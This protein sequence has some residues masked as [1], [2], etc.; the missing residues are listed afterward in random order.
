MEGRLENDDRLIFLMSRAQHCLR[1]HLKLAFERE[2]LGMTPVQ[3]GI[4]FLLQQKARTM[5]SISRELTIDNSATTGLV[6]RL[7]K[8][9]LAKRRPHPKDRRTVLIEITELGRQSI[10][11]AYH[12][13]RNV[14]SEIK[15]GFSV[16]EISIFKSIL[17]SFFIK[18][19]KE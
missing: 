18:F 2:G 1:N 7:E 6:D 12:I 16:E 8:A 9:G 13:V 10:E 3:S 15:A 4:L 19:K 5:T 17:N 14:N 11:K